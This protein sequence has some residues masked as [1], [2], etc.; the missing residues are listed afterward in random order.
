MGKIADLLKIKISKITRGEIK[1]ELTFAPDVYEVLKHEATNF[2]NEI[3]AIGT[4][5][6]E[7]GI[8]KV[9]IIKI[10]EQERFPYLVRVKEF[11]KGFNAVFHLHPYGVQ[12][13]SRM[14]YEYLNQNYDV[15]IVVDVTGNGMVCV[16]DNE[17]EVFI[18]DGF[19][20]KWL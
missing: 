18:V 5:E 3:A 4:A 15:S 12:S 13:F 19:K 14:D 6:F 8:W 10:P 2:Q 9:H 20:L 11:P 7:D 16:R 17:N 1:V